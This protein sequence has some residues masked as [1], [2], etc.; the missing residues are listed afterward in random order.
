MTDKNKFEIISQILIWGKFL[1]I[2]I[3]QVGIDGV[4]RSERPLVVY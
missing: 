1:F 4:D 2:M 3:G